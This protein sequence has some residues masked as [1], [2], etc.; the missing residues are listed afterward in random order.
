M[1]VS[2]R[3]SPPFACAVLL[4]VGGCATGIEDEA[5]VLDDGQVP[6]DLL[7]PATT[8]I[9]PPSTVVVP[10]GE[11][12]TIYLVKDNA[13]VA[14]TRT[15]DN[16]SLN[17]VVIEL[18][19]ALSPAEIAEG[20]RTLLEGDGKTP[21][22][23][24]VQLN[25]GV[26]TVEISPSFTELDGGSQLLALA[27]L[28]LTL[29]AQPGVGQVAFTSSGVVSPVPRANGTTTGEPVSRDDYVALLAGP[30]SSEPVG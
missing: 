29:T 20:L 22:V 14:R 24:G 12:E 2:R 5:H 3:I 28:V 4:V 11:V 17:S 16:E 18:A 19:A 25:N 10:A 1:R 8:T 23:V 13:V 7:L 9:A 27:Q 30:S 21:L 26:A 15:F 6:F